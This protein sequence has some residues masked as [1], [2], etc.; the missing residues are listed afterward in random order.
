[1]FYDTRIVKP[2][3]VIHFNGKEFRGSHEKPSVMCFGCG[4]N[5]RRVEVRV[6]DKKCYRCQVDLSK[7]I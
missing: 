1:M 7:V 4:F 5:V 6:N 2:E 3:D